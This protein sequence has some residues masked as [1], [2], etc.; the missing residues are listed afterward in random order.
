M[1][2]DIIKWLPTLLQRGQISAPAL[3]GKLPSRGDFIRHNLKHNQGLALQAWISE[4]LHPTQQTASAVPLST[5]I[6]PGSL[7]KKKA[8]VP[9]WHELGRP[10]SQPEISDENDGVAAE[11]AICPVSGHPGVPWSFVLPP[12]T[13][14]FAPQE[15]VIG[16]WMASSDSVGRHYPLVMIQIASPCWVK[17]YF[18]KHSQQPCDWLFAVA[19]EMAKTVYADETQADKPTG[20]GQVKDTFH[21]LVTRIVDLWQ[22]FRPG[23]KNIFW[24]LFFS[25]PVSS[26][27]TLADTP[28]PADPVRYLDG[29]R[30]LPWT[31]WPQKITAARAQPAFWQ[32]D[33]NGRFVAA[34]L[35]LNVCTPPA[36]SVDIVGLDK[37]DPL[38]PQLRQSADP[39]DIVRTTNVP[40]TARS[41]QDSP[42][43]SPTDALFATMHIDYV[44]AIVDPTALHTQ[45]LTL[46]SVRPNIGTDH[47]VIE[48]PEQPGIHTQNKTSLIDIAFGPLNINQVLEQLGTEES[49][50]SL[51]Q[52]HHDNILQLFATDIT[53]T[54]QRNRPP[55]LTRREH[56]T[57]SPD[58]YF[59][60]KRKT[61]T[62]GINNQ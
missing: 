11:A 1:S 19:R 13:L 21:D 42:A 8:N 55:E 16:V 40:A 36:P 43:L 30:Y 51:L 14:P 44:Q 45:Q 59:F 18:S 9:L 39:F 20:H 53:P 4:Q 57:I 37:A 23:W 49:D 3:W 46:P 32:Q 7:K 5:R 29:V 25:L 22:Q 35:S 26:L 38:H 41:Q 50:I 60:L 17:R 12:G 58:S 2:R 47:E 54:E 52:T 6:S 62:T 28:H 24:R 31:D 48:T 34:T 15:Y 27:H 33:L 61:V 10:V 56:H